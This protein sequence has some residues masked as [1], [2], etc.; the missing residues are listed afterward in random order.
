MGK[1]KFIF[2]YTSTRQWNTH[3]F[4]HFHYLSG[5]GGKKSLIYAFLSFPNLCHKSF[6]RRKS[7]FNLF[8]LQQMAVGVVFKQTFSISFKTNSC[9]MHPIT[10]KTH[11]F[12][13]SLREN[14]KL[15]GR[16]QLQYFLNFQR[17]LSGCKWCTYTRDRLFFS[18]PAHHYGKC[19]CFS[20]CAFFS[21]VFPY[22]SA[23][24]TIACE[25]NDVSKIDFPI[26]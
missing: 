24:E 25:C 14:R 7:R 8:D 16:R 17:Q 22:F 10:E 18:F 5:N 15:R 1:C 3:F 9:Q 13:F 20:R 26:Y 4:R 11:I 6:S 19:I 2:Q 23:Q 21:Q 12:I